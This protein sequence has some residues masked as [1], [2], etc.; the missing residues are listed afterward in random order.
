MQK[1]SLRER[2]DPAYT[3]IAI[4]VALVVVLL[5]WP[6]LTTWLSRATQPHLPPGPVSSGPPVPWP[7]IL[8]LADR[9]AARIDKDAALTFTALHAKAP[10]TLSSDYI[11][12][13]G[14]LTGSIRVS[15]EY[16]RP[17][18]ASF[19]LEL[20]DAAPE[21]TLVVYSDDPEDAQW[22][23]ESYRPQFSKAFRAGLSQMKI[24]PRDAVRLTW[25]EA[26]AEA[27]KTH[28]KEFSLEPWLL[29]APTYDQRVGVWMVFYELKE[30]KPPPD[31]NKTPTAVPTADP[32]RVNTP[33][34]ELM[35]FDIDP[36][37]GEILNRNYAMFPR[38]TPTP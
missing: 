28:L 10:G 22:A 16:I 38:G 19:T 15:L 18:G 17:N 6:A 20:E 37:T 4:A 26:Q 34:G 21:Q 8:A 36:F 25:D 3:A 11:K 30:P 32:H 1:P 24:A 7:T 2:I 29:F 14:P 5:A 9:E 33:L 31:G 27:Q 12:Y 13:S 35:N 23:K